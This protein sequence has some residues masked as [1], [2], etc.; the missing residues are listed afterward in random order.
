MCVVL[1]HPTNWTWKRMKNEL[2]LALTHIYAKCSSVSASLS[3]RYD[4]RLDADRV[5]EIKQQQQLHIDTICNGR[6]STVLARIVFSHDPLATVATATETAALVSTVRKIIQSFAV[7]GGQCYLYIPHLLTCAL[8]LPL[9][10]IFSLCKLWIYIFEISAHSSLVHSAPSLCLVLFFS[11]LLSAVVC[12]PLTMV[13][14]ETKYAFSE[15][16]MYVRPN[17]NDDHDDDEEEGKIFFLP[18]NFSPHMC[19]LSCSMSPK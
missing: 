3:G 2:E 16:F 11:F 10:A 12:W 19:S 1:T 4:N 8:S 5:R 7:S 14:A 9:F 6:I 18:L 17:I 13:A 15:I